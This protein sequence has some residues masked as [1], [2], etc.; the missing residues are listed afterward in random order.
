MKSY[1]LLLAMLLVPIIM[2]TSCVVDDHYELGEM[3]DPSQIH[4]RVEQDLN[5]GRK[6]LVTLA[7]NETTAPLWNGTV[8]RAAPEADPVSRTV[9]VFDRTA[10][11]PLPRCYVKV[12]VE[13]MDG[14]VRFHKDGYTDLRGM[15]DYGSHTGSEG[16]DFRRV[17]IFMSHPEHGARIEVV[18]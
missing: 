16:S 17:S 8:V 3:L 5:A 4:F 18:E 1:K 12:F 2:V 9:Q 13:G 6:P 14:A 15:F 7:P 10:R 11:T